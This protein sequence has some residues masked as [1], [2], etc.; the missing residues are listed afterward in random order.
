MA[1]KLSEFVQGPLLIANINWD[2]IM[3]KYYINDFPWHLVFRPSANFYGGLIKHCLST[4]RKNAYK[5]FT[6]MKSLL[7]AIISVLLNL[8]S[9]CKTDPVY[10]LNCDYF[11]VCH[12]WTIDNK[13]LHHRLVMLLTGI[14]DATVNNVFL[15]VANVVDWDTLHKT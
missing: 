9:V 13:F 2:F 15:S 7:H 4:A 12:W 8:I 11:T 14:Y 5:W 10:K 1:R 3:T 6:L